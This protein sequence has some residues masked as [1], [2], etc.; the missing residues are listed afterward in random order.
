MREL[1]R[2]P[3]EGRKKIFEVRELDSDISFIRNYLTKELVEELD[4]YIFQK[5]GNEWSITDKSWE[6]VREQLVMSRINGGHP[7][8]VVQNGDYLQNGELYLVHRYE[9]T[10]LDVKYLENTLPH[11]FAL[12]GRTV[13][14][15]TVIEGRKVLFTQ[16]GQKCTRRFL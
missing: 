11:V 7:V 4:L 15:E 16:N 5:Q 1:G 3:G 9:G 13:H 2:K 12:W 6:L 14:L 8:I 10:E